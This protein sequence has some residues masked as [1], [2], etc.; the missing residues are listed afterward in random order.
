[1]NRMGPILSI[2]FI[3]VTTSGLRRVDLAARR[4]RLAAPLLQALRLL[5][6]LLEQVLLH[7]A[8]GEEQAAHH[9]AL[10]DGEGAGDL[11]VRESL[12]LAQHDDGAVD[13]GQ[14]LEGDAD[15]IA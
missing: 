5:A 7:G 13:L 12:D 6:L 2:L 3:P 1:M 9:R 4:Y 10:L 8:A 15:L 14:A 11:G